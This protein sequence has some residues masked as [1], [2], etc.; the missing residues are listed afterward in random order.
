MISQY[1]ESFSKAA[2]T[3]LFEMC[4]EEFISSGEPVECKGVSRGGSDLVV[5][6]PFYGTVK[7]HYLLVVSKESAEF[8]TS[9]VDPSLVKELKHSVLCELLNTAVGEAV[10]PLIQNF[11][12]I[13]VFSPILSSC[14]IEYPEVDSVKTTLT[15]DQGMC[16]DLYTLLEYQNTTLSGENIQEAVT[17]VYNATEL[18]SQ[19]L[20]V[21]A[22]ELKT[23]LNSVLGVTD[24][25]LEENLSD[26]QRKMMSS[27]KVS[28]ENINNIINSILEYLSLGSQDSELNESQFNL[29]NILANLRE[30]AISDIQGKN[31][32]INVNLNQTVPHIVGDSVKLEKALS[33][34]INNAVKFT[35]KG[36]I[37]I[38]VT[39][40][41][42][43]EN[44]QELEFTIK[45]TGIG[46]PENALKRVLEPF[47]KVDSSI[48]R[49]HRGIGLG[50]PICQRLL[51]KLGGTLSI[52]SEAGRGSRISFKLQ[53]KLASNSKSVSPYFERKKSS[54]FSS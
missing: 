36:Q 39:S 49:E 7:G 41:M 24:L 51:E 1:G 12:D 40:A 33:L 2:C 5:A 19:Y 37:D 11:K 23:P 17:K 43:S 26:E 53:F 30:T 50:L 46:I 48:T 9:K 34:L 3:A 16:I 54:S 6:L 29:E 42:N 52:E 8:L 27:L 45:D 15:N 38:E 31:L 35:E 44:I 28:S 14:P 47:E 4:G 13:K 22:H 32:S 10:L 21:M 25:L 20:E 18:K